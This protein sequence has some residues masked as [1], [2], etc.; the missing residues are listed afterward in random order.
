MLLINQSEGHQIPY[1]YYQLLPSIYQ[2][3]KRENVADY[4]L[5]YNHIENRKKKIL[6]NACNFDA[7]IVSV[8]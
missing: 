6:K 3:L 1:Y 5:L 7:H 2:S 8:S 4:S